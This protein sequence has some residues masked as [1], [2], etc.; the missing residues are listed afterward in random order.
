M[1]AI[2][3]GRGLGSLEDLRTAPLVVATVAHEE[4]RRHGIR[5]LL[6]YTLDDLGSLFEGFLETGE[7]HGLEPAIDGSLDILEIGQ[8]RDGLGFE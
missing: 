5:V 3:G 8:R 1:G 4:Q 2:P 7:H 6:G